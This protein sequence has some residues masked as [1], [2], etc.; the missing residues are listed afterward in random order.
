M[1]SF[2]AGVVWVGVLVFAWGQASA[3][4]QGFRE[5]FERVPRSANAVMAIDVEAVLQT[6]MA[7]ANGLAT[8]LEA[9]YS[10]RATYLPP[11]AQKIVVASRLSPTSSFEQEWE[12]ALM[13]LSETIPPRFM[14][15]L[16]GGYVDEIAGTE[17]VW[18][19]SGAY[20]VPLSGNRLAVA[21]PDDR[22]AVAR[23]IDG[24]FSGG[25]AV[26][27]F[28]EAAVD[29]ADPDA[30]I[31]LAMD[32]KDL[33]QPGRVR[34]RIQNS[35]AFSGSDIPIDSAVELLTSLEGIVLQISIDDQA[36][37]EMR[38][39]FGQDASLLRPIARDLLLGVFNELGIG[40]PGLSQWDVR[41]ES[42]AVIA[43]GPLEQDEL[44][45]I[46]SLLEIPTTKFSELEGQEP[47]QDKKDVVAKTTLNYYRSL[48]TLVDD[49]K[50][51]VEKARRQ[52]AGYESVWY[53]RYARKIDRLPI[54][55]VDEQMLAFGQSVAETF[56]SVALGARS[57]RVQGGAAKASINVSGDYSN[58]GGW[59][60]GSYSGGRSGWGYGDYGSGYYVGYTDTRN[61]VE[62][63]KDD[64]RAYGQAARQIDTA[65]QAKIT[66][67][68]FSTAAELE[69]AMTDI[70]T[71]MT[72]R[73]GVEF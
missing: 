35:P 70:R 46:M 27:T 13:T 29:G 12:L 49:A 24:V 47:G 67:S 9:E 20:L 45:R 39:Q 38:I 58:R 61:N 10:D 33:P 43:K 37:G 19:P 64:V 72:K 60:A 18:T 55:N 66:I 14:A 1:K 34:E 31:V 48:E 44:R 50:D 32:L 8:K 4:A 68:V 7:K 71:V 51:A 53:E 42:H 56:R 69:N 62:R 25:G 23:W 11:E 52:R 65:N 21:A 30:Q 54:L 22:Q 59:H 17:A 15:K 63:A 26:T 73:Y 2:G 36:E 3:D 16:E 41:T 6:E 57:T 40:W 5:L 28:L